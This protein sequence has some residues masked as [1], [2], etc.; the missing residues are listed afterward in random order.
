[1]RSPGL[2]ASST[3]RAALPA[4]SRSSAYEITRCPISS[5]GAS[6]LPFDSN[7]STTLLISSVRH[8]LAGQHGEDLRDALHL[9][10]LVDVELDFELAL[11]VRDHGH[12]PDRVPFL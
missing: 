5:A 7:R 3:A 11:H 1:M 8:A 10:D 6:L 4:S 9:H 2:E 12:V